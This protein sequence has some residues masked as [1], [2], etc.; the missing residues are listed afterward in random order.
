MANDR[1]YR[2][3]SA[4]IAAQDPARPADAAGIA[5]DADTVAVVDGRI[6]WV[7]L[8][9][10]LSPVHRDLPAE[11]A[12]RAL[13]TPALIDCHT[14]IVHGGDRAREFAMRLEGARYEDIARAGGGIL[15]TVRATR[16]LDEA[17]LVAE[18]LPRVDRLLSEGVATLEIKSG[19]GLT[20]DSELTMLRAARRLAQVRPVRVRTTW[21]AAHALPPEYEGRADAYLEDVCL[22][23]LRQADAEG[24]VDAVDAFC[25]TI[26]FSPDQVARLFDLAR[27]L[28]LPVKLHA[29]QLSDQGGAALVARSGGLSADHLEWLDDAG[30]AAMAKAGTVAVML[31]GA[32][33]TLRETRL[34]PVEAL[35]AAGVPMAVATDCNPGT[36][37]LDSLLLAM[38]MACTLFRLTPAEA[39]SGTTRHAAAA[40]GLDDAGVIAPG[41]RADLAL[42]DV[43][44]PAA[45][46]YRIGAN[47]L[48]RRFFAGAEA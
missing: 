26:A 9:D 16:A 29:E 10:D 34:P 12:K 18:A 44:D 33:Y 38:N 45:L 36:S 5:T 14:H 39:L 1:S 8:R 21:L 40:L 2:I 48:R 32:F 30:I 42:W 47:P 13:L 7:G 23:G 15:S 17:A 41:R 27:D 3:D 22:E 6:A 28:G 43:T 20:I 19:Y 25:E 35:R 4:R 24:L 37:P 31:P 46:S 11:D